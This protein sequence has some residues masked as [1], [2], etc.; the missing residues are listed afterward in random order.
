MREYGSAL[1]SF[2]EASESDPGNPAHLM[3]RAY[4]EYLSAEKNSDS[5]GNIY[6]DN[7]ASVLDTLDKAHRMIEPEE[8]D[9]TLPPW[10][11]REKKTPDEKEFDAMSDILYFKARCY[12]KLGDYDKTLKALNECARPG[13]GDKRDVK[14]VLKIVWKNYSAP[15]LWRWWLAAPVNP[16]PKRILFFSVSLLASGLLLAH[17]LLVELIKPYAV[18]TA[19]YISLVAVL[20][21]ILFMPLTER[22]RETGYEFSLAPDLRRDPVLTPVTLDGHIKQI[23]RNLSA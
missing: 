2:R 6:R 21:G 12:F 19:V 4:A 14:R 18:N 16:W 3:W 20:I 22:T 15:S 5:G 8:K 7:I 13:A 10:I 9:E 23:R 17:P 11:H 1:E